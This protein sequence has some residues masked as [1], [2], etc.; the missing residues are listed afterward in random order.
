MTVDCVEMGS[1]ICDRFLKGLLLRHH[2]QLHIIFFNDLGR[3]SDVD[4][5]KICSK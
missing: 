1:V 5:K 2:C 4:V 3:E